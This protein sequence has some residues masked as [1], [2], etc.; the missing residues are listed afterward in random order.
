MA[1]SPYT[2]QTL[3]VSRHLCTTLWQRVYRKYPWIPL[4]QEFLDV[5][6]DDLPGMSP[7]RDIEFKIEL[8]P[9]TTPVAKSPYKVT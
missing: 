4:V 6:P 7:K 9:G 5:F 3:F 8:Q 2:S 1:R